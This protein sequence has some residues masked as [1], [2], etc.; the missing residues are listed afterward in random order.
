VLVLMNGLLL[1]GLRRRLLP[2][3]RAAKAALPV[4]LS[5]ALAVAEYSCYALALLQVRDGRCL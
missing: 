3:R 1:L 4:P 2:L 5:L